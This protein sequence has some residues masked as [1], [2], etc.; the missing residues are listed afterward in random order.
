MSTIDELHVTF[1]GDGTDFSAKREAD[2]YIRQ[3]GWTVGPSSR[4]G[5]RAVMFGPDWIVAKYHNL[6]SEE[7]AG[8]HAYL[9]GRGRSGPLTLTTKQPL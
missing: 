4:F 7:K 8:T 9:V 5:V 2:T 1:T 3:Q 6:T